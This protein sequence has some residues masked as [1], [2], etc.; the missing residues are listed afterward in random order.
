MNQ[1]L[2][3]RSS[4]RKGFSKYKWGDIPL[5]V[6]NISDQPQTIYKHTHAANFEVVNPPEVVRVDSVE[7]S[8]KL[9][10]EVPLHLKE[11]Y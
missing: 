1:L 6:A 5:R 7:T 8:N 4:N 10:T 3:E 11:V 9:E 2:K